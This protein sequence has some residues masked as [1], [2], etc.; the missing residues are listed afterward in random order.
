MK[1]F[2]NDQRVIV[3]QHA[4][5]LNGLAGTVVRLRRAD[6]GAWVK[7]DERREG[8]PWDFPADDPAGRGSHALLWPEN[9]SPVGKT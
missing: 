6:N 1:A 4:H 9:C 7:M 2:N 3:T 8:F 5:A